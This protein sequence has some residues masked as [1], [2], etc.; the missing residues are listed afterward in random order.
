MI[1]KIRSTAALRHLLPVDFAVLPDREFVALSVC[2]CLRDHVDWRAI[3]PTHLVLCG[4]GEHFLR[5]HRACRVIPSVERLW[6]LW[7][8]R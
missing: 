2:I 8:V 4:L 7:G 3:G 1:G 5:E 6:L